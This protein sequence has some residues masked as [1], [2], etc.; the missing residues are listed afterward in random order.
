MRSPSK[1]VYLIDNSGSPEPLTNRYP[2]RT[3]KPEYLIASTAD[4]HHGADNGAASIPALHS[5]NDT[6]IRQA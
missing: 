1:H 6:D 5:A 2:E 4:K 3:P